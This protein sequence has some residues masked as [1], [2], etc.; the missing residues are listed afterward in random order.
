MRAEHQSA[1]AIGQLNE[2][3]LR[4]AE[5]PEVDS[6]VR[7][8][9]VLGAECTGKSQLCQA[10]ARGLP[11]ITFTEVLRDWVAVEGRSPNAE[12][13]FQLFVRQKQVEEQAV[14]DARRAGYRWVICDSA[15]LMTAVYSLYYFSDDRLLEAAV[16]HHAGYAQTILCADD[17][18][19]VPDPGQRDGETARKRVQAQ[20][21]KTLG[22]CCPQAVLVEG[23]GDARLNRALEALSGE[24]S[25]QSTARS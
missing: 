16:A 12:E 1:L 3:A 25:R 18:P 13:Q 14:I 24:R 19:W 20:L 8:V 11:G 6:G 22:Q 9:A 10:I 2:A 21:I 7:R 15:P 5:S 23:L 4:T 17:I